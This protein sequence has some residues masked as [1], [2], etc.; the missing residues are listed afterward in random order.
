DNL[1]DGTRVARVEIEDQN[2]LLNIPV[3][4][5]PNGTDV[6][7]YLIIYGTAPNY[8]IS[9]SNGS[10]TEDSAQPR[11]TIASVNNGFELSFK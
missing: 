11:M 5:L 4:L 3:S 1:G 6:G 2:D 7:S 8:V 10:E 9:A